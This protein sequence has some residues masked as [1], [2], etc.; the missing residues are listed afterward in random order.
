MST[1]KT[2]YLGLNQWE[3]Q[4]K[5]DHLEFNED[6]AKIDNAVKQLQ[7]ALPIDWFDAGAAIPQGADL[8]TFTENGKYYCT[9]SAY[10]KTLLNCPVMNDNF[11]MFVFRR[12]SGK[13]L[14]QMIITLGGALY[15]RGSDSGGSYRT[16]S[17]KQDA[18]AFAAHTSDVSNPHDVTAAQIGALV[19]GGR[20][21]NID[22]LDED[23]LFKTYDESD[24][25]FPSDITYNTGV[26]LHKTWDEKYK[27][28]IFVSN[29][30]RHIYHRNMRRGAWE[31]WK[32]VV[33]TDFG[34]MKIETG[35]YVGNGNYGSTTPNSLT[36][37]F[38]PKIV[39][40]FETNGPLCTGFENNVNAL[41]GN[42]ICYM[43]AVK[44]EYTKNSPWIIRKV[45]NGTEYDSYGKRSADGKTLY[46]YHEWSSASY[47]FNV[48]AETYHYVALG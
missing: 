1:G 41:S 36:F 10:S 4:D 39:M 17:E 12:T 5:F 22:S 18:A 40:I 37:E 33:T 16:W 27:E 46:W 11:V 42:A 44:E 19:N 29:E 47:Q 28:Q 9:S 25:T 21:S 26:L 48:S 31:N 7:E 45:D 20:V 32:G 8:N 34:V 2:Q 15:I 30:T 3:L 35:S 24:G 6:N 38:A 23:G 13:S 14:A 43:S